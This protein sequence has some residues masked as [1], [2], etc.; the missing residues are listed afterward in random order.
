VS[1]NPTANNTLTLPTASGTVALLADAEKVKQEVQTASNY[2][3]W[4]PL[5]VGS[6]NSSTAGFTPVT[7]TDKTYVFSTI[8][9]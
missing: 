7:V 1:G 3:N 2:T 6:S 9:V 5:V 4:R 8:S